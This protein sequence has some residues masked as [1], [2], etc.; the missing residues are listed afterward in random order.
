MD[1]KHL[2]FVVCISHTSL[3]HDLKI[4]KCFQSIVTNLPLLGKCTS[5][6]VIRRQLANGHV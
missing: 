3:S 1:V 6:L 4:L 2:A 5:H